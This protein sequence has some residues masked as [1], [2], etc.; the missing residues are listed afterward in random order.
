MGLPREVAQEMVN[1]TLLGA[2]HYACV[3]KQHP[4]I[5]RNDITSPGGT[6]AAALFEA[7][8][9]GLRSAMSNTIWAAYHRS[10]ELGEKGKAGKGASIL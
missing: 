8:K 2:A 10:V 6:T 7:E 5:L 9:N 4:A 1:E 3:S